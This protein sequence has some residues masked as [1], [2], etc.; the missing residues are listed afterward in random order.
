LYRIYG[1]AHCWE[2]SSKNLAV[3]RS[4]KIF[5]VAEPETEDSEEALRL[6]YDRRRA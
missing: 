5:N 3:L 6:Y 4:N 1:E 2:C